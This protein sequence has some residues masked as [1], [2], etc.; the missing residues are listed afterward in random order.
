MKRRSLLKC[1]GLTPLIATP[2]VGATLKAPVKKEFPTSIAELVQ[3][4]EKRHKVGPGFSMDDPSYAVTGEPYIVMYNGVL[5]PETSAGFSCKSLSQALKA[6]WLGFLAYSEVMGPQAVLYWRV[7]PEHRIDTGNLTMTGFPGS[8]PTFT[9]EFEKREY[10]KQG[11]RMRFLL[12][13][14]E[15]KKENIN[16]ISGHSDD[17][18]MLTSI[19]HPEPIW[20]KELLNK[21]AGN[22]QTHT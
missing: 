9:N 20:S 15:P 11:V 13:T 4:M 14:K 6:T 5:K 10:E 1:L 17:G 22:V 8:A 19:E 7:P 3:W 18:I 21:F 16:Q 2:V 12:S